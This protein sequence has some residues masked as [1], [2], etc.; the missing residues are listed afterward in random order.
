LSKVKKIKLSNFNLENLNNSEYMFGE[1]YNLKEIIFNNNTRTNNLK[2][3]DSMFQYCRSLEYIDTNIFI[4]DN[5]LSFNYI[6][7]GCYSLKEINLSHFETKN[8]KTLKG[9]FRY[10]ESLEKIDISNFDTSNVFSIS[11]IFNGCINLKIINISSFNTTNF[12]NVEMAFYNCQS[13]T[14]LDLSNFDFGKVEKASKMFYN[15]QK[16]KYINLPDKMKSLE[17]ADYMFQNCY[18]LSSLN[19]EFLHETFQWR[20]ATGLFKDCISLTELNFPGSFPIFHSTKEMFS[21]CINLKSI[22]LGGIS[23][24]GDISDVSMMFYNCKSLEYLNIN[25][26]NTKSADY[27]DNMFKGIGENITIIYNPEITRSNINEQ[28]KNLKPK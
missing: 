7:D 4:I 18:N 24:R 11:E 1:C 6:F 3:M 13:L 27:S 16:L 25:H 2:K 17:E 22:N 19:L 23:N 28:I 26:L 9:T 5:V 14:G 8:I 20:I 12:V 15:C 10:C 21:G